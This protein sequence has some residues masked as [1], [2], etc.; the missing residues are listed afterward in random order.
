MKKFTAILTA[1]MLLA[2]TACGSEDK[3]LETMKLDQYVTLGEYMGLEIPVSAVTVTD[4]EVEE[5]VVY[6]GQN[7][8]TDENGIKDRAA[9]LGDTINLDYAGYLDGVAFEGGTAQAQ[10][11]TLGSGQFIPGFEDGLVGVN[12]GETLDLPLT[13]PET[14]GNTELAGKEVIF[15]VTVNYIYPGANEMN[16]AFVAALNDENYTNRAELDQFA[17]DYLYAEKEYENELAVSDQ[18]IEM[19]IGNASIHE[20][21]E[22]LVE[23]CEQI[24]TDSVNQVASMYG[25]DADTYLMYAYYTDLATYVSTYGDEVA[26]QHLVFMAIAQQEDLVISDEEY[27]AILLEDAKAAGFETVEEYLGDADKALQKK[28]YILDKVLAFVTENAMLVE[29]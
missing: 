9:Q 22:G 21:P 13:F 11:L 26:K 27:D 4:E 18:I 5:L 1:A 2:L 28:Y 7:Y 17:Y 6:I 3:S 12:P 23:E 20:M 16:D 29:Q 24:L 19:V 14:Y 10:Q 25:M 8:M 15:T